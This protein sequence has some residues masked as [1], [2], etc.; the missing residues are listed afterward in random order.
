MPS[1][2][3]PVAPSSIRARLE[4]PRSAAAPIV[5]L[6]EAKND[7]PRRFISSEAKNDTMGP[8][9]I[10]TRSVAL[11]ATGARLFRHLYETE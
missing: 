4:S 2:P 11:V 7:K 10:I 6:S 1:A 3:C 9:S 5:I 8:S